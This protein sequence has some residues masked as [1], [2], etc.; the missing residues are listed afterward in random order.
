MRI[1][2]LLLRLIITGAILYLVY[3]KVPISDVLASLKVADPVF[4]GI[5]CLLVVGIHFLAAWR[6]R[7]L[8][9]QQELIVGYWRL[10]VIVLESLFYRAFLPGGSIATLTARFLK[11]QTVTQSRSR[12][13]ATLAIDRIFAT[14]SLVGVGIVFALLAR[15]TLFDPVG[16][17]LLVMAVLVVLLYIATVHGAA[18]NLLVGTFRALRQRRL[19]ELAERGVQPLTVF[20]KMRPGSFFLVVALSVAPHLIGIGV[21]SLLAAAIGIDIPV[22]SWGWIRS[23]V[24]LTTMLPISLLGIGVREASV[25]YLL[26]TFG[27]ADEACLALAMLIFAVSVLFIALLGGLLELGRLIGRRH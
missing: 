12:T 14:L 21:Y 4:L 1:S 2:K 11:L 16:S 25:L 9:R 23:L 8:L 5:A 20:Q 10:F 7:I 17:V 3:R 26:Q 22:L 6:L 24:I 27:V 18:G 15:K 19:S 13:L